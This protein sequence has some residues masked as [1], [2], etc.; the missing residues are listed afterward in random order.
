MKISN[1]SFKKREG[2]SKKLPLEVALKESSG[3]NFFVLFTSDRLQ[4]GSD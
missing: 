2:A 3:L 4:I 1:Y